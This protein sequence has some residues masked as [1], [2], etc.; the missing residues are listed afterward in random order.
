MTQLTLNDEQVQAI[1]QAPGDVEL[2]DRSGIVVGYVTRRALATPEEIAE[3]LKRAAS[4]GP[5]HTTEQFLAR[6]HA[7]QQQ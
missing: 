5:W 2:R 6:L 4:P 3:A 7:L 1:R